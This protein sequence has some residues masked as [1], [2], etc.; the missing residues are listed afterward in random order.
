VEQAFTDADVTVNPRFGVW[1]P[2]F[3]DDGGLTL[4]V[5]TDPLGELVPA[6]AGGTAPNPLDPLAPAVE[7]PTDGQG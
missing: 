6:G 3:T 2:A 7:P 1:D 5:P 4:I